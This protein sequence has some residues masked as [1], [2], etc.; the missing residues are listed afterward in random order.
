MRPPL[1]Q[2]SGQ[3]LPRT[4]TSRL[5]EEGGLVIRNA[6]KTRASA[7]TVFVTASCSRFAMSKAS[8]SALVGV[9]LGDEKPKYLNS[10]ETPLFHK[11]RE[12]YGLYEAR[13]AL[14]DSGYALVCRGLYGRGGPGP[15]GLSQCRGHPGH[16]LHQPTICTS[17]FA[18]PRPVVFSFDGDSR[19]PPRSAQSIGGSPALAERHAQHQILIPACRA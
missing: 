15:A 17:C 10:P 3:R 12:L 2:F 6:T 19:G 4:M 1:A 8:A 11:G 14:R 13:T 16:R 5:L 9:S 7:T 18:L